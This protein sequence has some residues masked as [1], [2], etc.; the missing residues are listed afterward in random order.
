[1]GS[2]KI[3]LAR[4]KTPVNREERQSDMNYFD[5]P[6]KNR[7]PTEKEKHDMLDVIYSTPH[8]KTDFGL[9]PGNDIGFDINPFTN[10][11]DDFDM[12]S[13]AIPYRPFV[14]KLIDD[15]D[16]LFSLSD[17]DCGDVSPYSWHILPPPV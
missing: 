5:F 6:N 12:S 10:I 8:D 9:I 11:K 17:L 13:I 1:M 7:E 15:H 3:H 16:G 4:D 2:G 14:R